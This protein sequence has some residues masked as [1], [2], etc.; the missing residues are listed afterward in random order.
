MGAQVLS[1]AMSGPCPPQCSW[2]AIAHY[3]FGIHYVT[4]LNTQMMMLNEQRVLL[5]NEIAIIEEAA[6]WEQQWH[7]VR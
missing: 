6:R 3:D 5:T 2:K 7:N 1:R 4:V